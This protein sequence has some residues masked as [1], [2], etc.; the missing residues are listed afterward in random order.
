METFPRNWPF[1]PGIHHRAHYN[2]TVM[3]EM[4]PWV[5]GTPNVVHQNVTTLVCAFN[6]FRKKSQYDLWSKFW[7]CRS[8]CASPVRCQHKICFDGI[9]HRYYIK[10]K[11]PANIYY[12]SHCI[13]TYIIIITHVRF[14]IVIPI[15][16]KIIRRVAQHTCSNI[17][18]IEVHI[19]GHHTMDVI[20][21][22][23]NDALFN[24]LTL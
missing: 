5:H 3:P 2:V 14:V 13:R 6:R 22:V 12:V 21:S 24:R 8:V 23:Y 7:L 18:I 15:Y 10:E 9:A 4:C 1:V 16:L 11:Y 19:A 17:I 20:T